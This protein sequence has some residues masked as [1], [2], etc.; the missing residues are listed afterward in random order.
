MENFGIINVWIEHYYFLTGT[1]ENIFFW[2]EFCYRNLKKKK[3][4]QGHAGKT[5]IKNIQLFALS[6]NWYKTMV[7]LQ[8]ISPGGNGVS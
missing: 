5:P 4:R 1:L 2:Q 6:P 3:K 7:N 8:S